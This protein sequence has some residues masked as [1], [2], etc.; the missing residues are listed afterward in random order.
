MQDLSDDQHEK[1]DADTTQTCKLKRRLNSVLSDLQRSHLLSRERNT[2]RRAVPV[3]GD[4]ESDALTE[5]VSMGHCEY[6]LQ[7]QPK[8]R[9]V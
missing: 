2:T 8:T 1:K 6:V 3:T 7:H 9:F 5:S 4:S